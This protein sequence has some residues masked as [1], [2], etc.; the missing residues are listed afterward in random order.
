MCVRLCVS[1]NGAPPADIIRRQHAGGEE[2]REQG[3]ERR[4]SGKGER[5]E[6]QMDYG[7]EKKRKIDDGSLGMVGIESE[8]AN[9][10]KEEKWKKLIKTRTH[11]KNTGEAK[12][13][14]DKQISEREN[15][16]DH[17]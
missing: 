2:N 8:Y 11:K 13:K 17:E 1:Q 7:K 9:K 14:I 3:D 10:K 15:E 4:I 12:E 6:K 16:Q 5:L